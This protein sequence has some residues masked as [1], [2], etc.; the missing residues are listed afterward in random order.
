MAARFDNAFVPNGK[1]Y[2]GMPRFDYNDRKD[3]SVASLL[4]G[5]TVIKVA[6]KN[7]IP[8]ATPEFRKKKHEIMHELLSLRAGKKNISAAK[9][10][11]VLVFDGDNYEPDK[12]PFSELIHDLMPFVAAVVCA[13]RRPRDYSAAFVEG[14]KGHENLYFVELDGEA[15]E[16]T[17]RHSQYI[18]NLYSKK[19]THREDGRKTDGFEQLER[20]MKRAT[21]VKEI[22]EGVV[23]MSFVPEEASSSMPLL[24]T[25]GVAV[26][27]LA[28]YAVHRLK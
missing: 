24:A 5:K 17:E 7:G 26:A 22:T 13:K 1:E 4:D 15:N 11:I 12:T 8:A 2:R 6:G 21:K 28:L 3:K 20:Q 18:I 27:G 25:I 14:W 16:W 23:L 10:N 19:Y 9:K